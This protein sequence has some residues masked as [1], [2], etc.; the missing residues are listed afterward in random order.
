MKTKN[1]LHRLIEELP[2][3]EMEAAGR[4][5]EYLRDM[6]DPLLRKLL[7]APEEDQELNDETLA[8]LEEARQEALRGEGRS[9][10]EVRE[11]DGLRLMM[12]DQAIKR[13]K[14][15]VR[16]FVPA[17]VSLVDELLQDRREIRHAAE[18][19]L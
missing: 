5:L 6:G 16:S 18:S 15:L 10:E 8:T 14:A 2:E 13:A 9:W 4:Y 11:D 17:G 12:L 1:D 19:G 3:V 7:E